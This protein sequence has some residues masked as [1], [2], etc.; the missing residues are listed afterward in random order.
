MID[1]RTVGGASLSTVESN[2][3]PFYAQ[4]EVVTAPEAKEVSVVVN[5]TT[6]SNYQVSPAS[7][8]SP[9]TLVPTDEDGLLPLAVI[10]PGTTVSS[11]DGTKSYVLLVEADGAISVDLL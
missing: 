2:E 9:N 4:D 3:W 1:K 11:R 8:P 7:N 6:L 5:A 10:P